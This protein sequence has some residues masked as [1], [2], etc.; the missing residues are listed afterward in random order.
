MLK[1][2]KNFSVLFSISVTF[3]VLICLIGLTAALP[4]LV[5]LYLM[6]VHPALL[7]ISYTAILINLYAVLPPAYLA[8][9]ALL[10]LLQLVRQEAVFS[11]K[12]VSCLRLISWCCFAETVIFAVLAG[13]FWLSLLLSF[14]TLFMG[15]IL[16]VV[17]NVIEEAAA[18]K[19]E[20][21]WTV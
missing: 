8:D 19:D 5:R 16:R 20:N 9:I 1:I 7:E 17:K 2:N 11:E 15:L 4:F 3:V 21:D 14:A 13:F 18:I 6:N 12:A 10:R